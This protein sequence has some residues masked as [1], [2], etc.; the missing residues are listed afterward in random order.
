[1]KPATPPLLPLLLDAV[2]D[3]LASMLAQ[4]GIPT[5]KFQPG[6]SNGRFVLFDSHTRRDHPLLTSQQQAI[7]VDTLRKRLADQGLGSD[8]FASIETAVASRA[9]WRVGEWDATEEIAA[10]DRRAIREQVMNLLRAEVDRRGGVWMRVA[11]YPRPYRT[12]ANFRFDH[13]EFVAEDFERTL[14]A[15]AP[16]SSMTTHFVCGSTHERHADAV[17][18]LAGLDIGS[19]GYRHH[20]YRTAA[21]NIANIERGIAVLRGCGIEPAGFAAPHGRYNPGLATALE[22]LGITHSSEFGFAYD[23]LPFFPTRTDVLQI[24]IHPVCLGIVLEAAADLAVNRQVL[25]ESTRR[26]AVEATI[27]HFLAAAD[28]LHAARIPIFFYGHPD[29]RVGRYPELLRRVLGSISQLPDVWRTSLFEFQRWWRLRNR[30]ELEVYATDDGWLVAA[31][32]LPQQCPCSLEIVDEDRTASVALDRAR[33]RIARGA[34]SFA[35]REPYR[36][37]APVRLPK[38]LDVKAILRRALDWERV[39]P[40]DEIDAGHWSGMMKKTLRR[41]RG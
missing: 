8:A 25:D 27:E 30:I 18:K 16:H 4:E 23:E 29:G 36:L 20:T 39:T 3:A 21:E 28:S 26:E 33:L 35:S 12:V 10:M 6:R 37:P 24:P 31:D 22:T 19:H 14:D 41:I 13:D 1:M 17:R 34:L 2:P 15:I 5:V 11:P 40:V 38:P 9:A 32:R 7:D